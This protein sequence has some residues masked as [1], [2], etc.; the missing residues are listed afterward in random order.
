M[1]PLS[2]VTSLVVTEF[3]ARISIHLLDVPGLA[4]LIAIEIFGAVSHMRQNCHSNDARIALERSEQI[5]PYDRKAVAAALNVALE[6]L[7]LYAQDSESRGH[8]PKLGFVPLSDSEWDAVKAVL[9]KLPVAKP[10]ASWNDKTFV[11]AVLWLIAAKERGYSW[12][13][14]PP[15][16]G[17]QPSREGRHRRWCL[18]NYWPEIAAKLAVDP[19][20]SPQRL[21]DFERIAEDAVKRKAMLLERRARLTDGGLRQSHPDFRAF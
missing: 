8:V 17:P 14:L 5:L 6:T 3:I 18:L 10:N 15:E 7:P 13:R 11:E 12:H 20:I 21:R 16:L 4:F 19:R 9:P 1:Q 2:S